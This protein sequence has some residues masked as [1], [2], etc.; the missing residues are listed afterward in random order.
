VP[1]TSEQDP[2]TQNPE[3]QSQSLEHR[4]SVHPPI[5]AVTW[6]TKLAGQPVWLHGSATQPCPSAAAAPTWQTN[7]VG[8]VYPAL[9]STGTQPKPSAPFVPGEQVV[10]AGQGATPG[11]LHERL[12]VVGRWLQKHTVG[13]VKQKSF[14]GQSVSTVHDCRGGVGQ[15]EVHALVFPVGLISQ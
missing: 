9:Q 13:P 2:L 14:I 5:V 15:D 7:P 8:H 3:S 11:A 6:Q 10:P 12:Q 1:T 4:F